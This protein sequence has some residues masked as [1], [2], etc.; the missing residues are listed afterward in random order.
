MNFQNKAFGA[1]LKELRKLRRMTQEDLGKEMGVEQAT[2]ARWESGLHDPGEATVRKLAK[3][4]NED[5]LKIWL[6]EVSDQ[7]VSQL[8][9]PSDLDSLVSHLSNKTEKIQ[10]LEAD[11]AVLRAQLL[12]WENRLMDVQIEFQRMK[13]VLS[14]IPE[15]IQELAPLV[16][17]LKWKGVLAFLGTEKKSSPVPTKKKKE[18]SD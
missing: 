1:R 16:S 4:F 10:Q 17:K 3:M 15:E 6:N 12:A 7:T 9:K 13:S 5:L 2:I 14:Y 18:A 8:V 11:N